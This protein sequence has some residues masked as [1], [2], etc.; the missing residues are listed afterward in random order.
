MEEQV[1]FSVWV[2]REMDLF[3]CPGLSSEVVTVG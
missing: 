2:N 3:G 1:C